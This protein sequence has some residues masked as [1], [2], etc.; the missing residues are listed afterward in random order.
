MP[1][2]QDLHWEIQ[3]HLRH[4]VADL[5]KTEDFRDQ[6]DDIISLARYHP[7]LYGKRLVRAQAVY[8]EVETLA[9]GPGME[10]RCVVAHDAWVRAYN[11]YRAMSEEYWSDELVE[12]VANCVKD[13]KLQLQV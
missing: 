3:K 8:D 12:V 2:R 11:W 1:I 4:P 10:E 5:V 7:T 6:Y 13:L 9:V